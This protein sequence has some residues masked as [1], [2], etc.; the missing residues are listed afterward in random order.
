MAS[1]VGRLLLH[2]GQH[3]VSRRILEILDVSSREEGTFI[4][5]RFKISV[6]R[7]HAQDRPLSSR[8]ERVT[9]LVGLEV[10]GSGV[11]KHVQWCRVMPQVCKSSQ[12]SNSRNTR[13]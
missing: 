4:P 11:G 8:R 9:V 5:Q 10:P 6:A 1:L 2:G 13:K 12:V 7:R 3:I